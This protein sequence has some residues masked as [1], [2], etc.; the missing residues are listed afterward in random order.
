M[1]RSQIPYTREQLL[2]RQPQ[3]P[4]TG[5]QLDEV[6]FPLGGIGTGM[7]SLGGWGQLRDW[8]IRNRPAKGSMVPEA[9]FTLKVREGKRTQTR[10][11]QGPV[12]GSFTGHGHS[13]STSAGEGLPHFREVSFRGRF[14]VANVRLKDPTMPVDVALEAFNPFIPLNDRDSGIPVAILTYRLRNRGQ[15]AVQATVFGNL[16]NIVGEGRE[17]K[18]VN[19][20]RRSRGLTGLLLSAEEGGQPAPDLGSMALTTPWPEASVWPKWKNGELAKFWEAIAESD[21]RERQHPVPHHLALPDLRALAQARGRLRGNVAQL[22]RHTLEGCLGRGRLHG[23]EPGTPAPRDHALP[24]HAARIDVA[25][26]RPRRGQREHLHPQVPHVPAARGRHLLRVR[27]LLGHPG[28]LRRL[29][30]ARLELR[31]GPPVP[32]P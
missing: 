24:R 6:A 14:P 26:T 30:H 2:G 25:D 12:G 22:L 3:P 18:R 15:R 23:G 32:L 5:R 29:V 27:G 31:P 4:L 10:V 17:V 21:G 7:V 9:F 13:V 16:T 11:L 20:A 1:R 19:A 28:V 8:E